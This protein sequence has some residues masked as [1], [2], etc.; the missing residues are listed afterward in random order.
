MVGPINASILADGMSPETRSSSNM[1][2]G[3]YDI[4]RESFSIRMIIYYVVL[5]R[6]VCMFYSRQLT[7]EQ[8]AMCRLV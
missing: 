6:K 1:A 3:S 8:R 4:I 5:V 2:C 7:N